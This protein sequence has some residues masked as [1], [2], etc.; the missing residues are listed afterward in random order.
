MSTTNVENVE[1][2][3]RPV[4]VSM[5]ISKEIEFKGGEFTTDRFIEFGAQEI[6]I[7]ARNHNIIDDRGRGFRIV[8][9]GKKKE[10]QELPANIVS[11]ITKQREADL[12]EL[13]VP[14]KQS[15]I[16]LIEQQTGYKLV[17]KDKKLILDDTHKKAEARNVLADKDEGR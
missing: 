7:V 8:E 13:K 16:D 10:V 4:F 11:L 6:G 15:D 5:D 12:G 9:V 17:I 3:K 1:P 2:N 14:I